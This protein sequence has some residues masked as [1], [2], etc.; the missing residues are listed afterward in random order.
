MYPP[1]TGMEMPFIIAASSE[2][3]KSTILL[4]D[5]ADLYVCQCHSFPARWVGECQKTYAFGA[6][7]SVQLSI[8]LR[9]KR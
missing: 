3:R 6:A 2:S 9:M 7:A 8:L 4:G 1:S 5:V